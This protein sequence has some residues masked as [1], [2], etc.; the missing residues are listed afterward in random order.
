MARFKWLAQVPE[1][2]HPQKQQ[3]LVH[4][5]VDEGPC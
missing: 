2:S 5:N 4:K 1:Q 3:K